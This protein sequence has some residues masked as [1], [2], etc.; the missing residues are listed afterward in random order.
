MYFYDPLE[1]YRNC[2]KCCYN[3]NVSESEDSDDIVCLYRVLAPSS[4]LSV[5]TRSRSGQSV[6]LSAPAE[7]GTK[8]STKSLKKIHSWGFSWILL[9]RESDE[10]SV[11]VTG[12]WRFRLRV[13]SGPWAWRDSTRTRRKCS[14]EEQRV[15][16][17]LFELLGAAMPKAVSLELFSDE[18]IIFYFV[19]E[20]VVVPWNW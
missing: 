7:S 5:G 3:S 12:S 6:Y 18:P 10:Q 13:S 4:A 17:T 15:S 20:P 9:E 14:W 1:L 8:I 11:T 2:G 19:L 16:A